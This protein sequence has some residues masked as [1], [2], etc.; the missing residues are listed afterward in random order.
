MRAREEVYFFEPSFDFNEL[1][2][3]FMKITIKTTNLKLNQA[4]KNFIEE[5][6]NSL[7][8]FSKKTIE[9]WVEIGKTTLH[10]QKGPFFRA[11]C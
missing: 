9:A 7:E 1:K 4:L 8:K 10:H 6:V 11:E 5:K 2:S 3:C